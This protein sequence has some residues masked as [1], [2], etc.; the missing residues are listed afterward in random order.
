MSI[1]GPCPYS[2]QVFENL[3]KHLKIKKVDGITQ[4]VTKFNC[5]T[6]QLILP[7]E[8][9][10]QSHIEKIHVNGRTKDIISCKVCDIDFIFL[11]SLNFHQAL[12]HEDQTLNP[13][14]IKMVPSPVQLHPCNYCGK[15]FTQ[16]FIKKHMME[17]HGIGRQNKEDVQDSTKSIEF[18]SCQ[19]CQKEFTNIFIKKHLKIKHNYEEK[20]MNLAQG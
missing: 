7:N 11:K 20:E 16:F 4:D 8:E 17:K 1:P 18:I 13:L 5:N 19:F 12:C 3:R 10:I 15:L 2:N 9:C 14:K 6:C